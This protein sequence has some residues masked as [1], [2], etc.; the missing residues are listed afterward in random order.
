MNIF[1]NILRWIAGSV[2]ISGVLITI[3]FINEVS[4]QERL[5]FSSIES[6]SILSYL[7]ASGQFLLDC[8]ILLLRLLSNTYFMIIATIAVI[9]VI[10]LIIIAPKF[11]KK[12]EYFKLKIHFIGLLCIFVLIS[13]IIFDLPSTKINNMLVKGLNTSIFYED[14]NLLSEITQWQYK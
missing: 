7:I 13:I 4:F 2:G 9:L 11:L 5:G 12:R 14:G 6:A 1:F 10:V 3:G 8:T